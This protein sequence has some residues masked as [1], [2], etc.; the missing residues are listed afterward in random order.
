MTET[1]IREAY[2]RM[3]TIDQTI[4][5]EVLDFMKNAAIEKLMIMQQREAE[6]KRICQ[7]CGM[8]P[9]WDIILTD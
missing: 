8:I 3:R 9:K 7:T 5:D 1:M 2:A 6:K 4:P